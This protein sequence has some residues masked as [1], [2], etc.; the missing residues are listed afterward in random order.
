MSPD[1]G[2]VLPSGIRRRQRQ[3]WSGTKPTENGSHLRQWTTWV[4]P[5]LSG[6]VMTCSTWLRSPQEPL[7]SPHEESLW[8]PGSWPRQTSFEPCANVSSN[9][10]THRQY[11]L[12]SVKVSESAASSTSSEC[13]ATRSCRSNE[14]PEI[15]DEVGQRSLESPGF[16]E[17]SMTQATLSADQSGIGS[18]LGCRRSSHTA[19]PSNDSRRSH[20]WLSVATPPESSPRCGHCD[21]HLH[22]PRSP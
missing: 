20:R 10:K 9:V 2:A 13:T 19:D 18:T 22:V 11:L 7:E 12:S 5:L 6:E 3:S 4:Q 16:T 14:P 17:D 21:S 1:P 15:Y 8:D